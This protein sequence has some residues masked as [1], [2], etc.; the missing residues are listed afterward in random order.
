MAINGISWIKNIF[1]PATSNDVK[2]H[3][4]AS[5]D[6]DPRR[7]SQDRQEKPKYLNPNQEQDAVDKLNALPNFSKSGLR[8][9]LV[10]AA[11]YAT[12]VVIKDS[13][14]AIIRRLTYDQLIELYLGRNSE[15]NTG[16]LINRAA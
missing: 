3:K 12:H 8:A 9:E 4:D 13:S 10:K 15:A 7:G 6:R 2:S 1:S 16:K 14:G 5:K 11:G